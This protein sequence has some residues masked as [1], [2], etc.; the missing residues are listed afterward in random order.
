[1]EDQSEHGNLQPDDRKESIISKVEE[2]TFIQANDSSVQLGFER[3]G[4][5][6]QLKR[7]PLD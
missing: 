4:R 7:M 6:L 2:R 5:L 3:V 1:M